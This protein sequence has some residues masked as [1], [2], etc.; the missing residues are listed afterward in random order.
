MNKAAAKF[1][2]YRI[3]E[4][5]LIAINNIMP[6][7]IADLH[8]AFVEKFLV[9]GKMNMIKQ[10]REMFIRVKNG[11]IVPVLTNLIV[12][13]LSRKHMILFF[14]KNTSFR[15][16]DE[17]FANVPF[18]FLLASSKYRLNELSYNFEK[19]TGVSQAAVKMYSD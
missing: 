8:Q 1:L 7:L 3:S 14:E 17:P 18:A 6:S 19:V 16:F 2:S 9:T 4:A 12:N 13:D 11:S 15:T 5:N 10:K